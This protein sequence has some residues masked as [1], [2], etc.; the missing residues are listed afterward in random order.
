M[1]TGGKRD[2]SYVK[3][4]REVLGYALRIAPLSNDSAIFEY[5]ANMPFFT[6]NLGA[7]QA[8]SLSLISSSGSFTWL[9]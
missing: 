2:G 4:V 5:T 7:F 9:F 8:L 1:K 3:K 6:F